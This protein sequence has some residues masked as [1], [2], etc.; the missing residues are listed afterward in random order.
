[1]AVATT[2]LLD[3]R[4]NGLGVSGVPLDTTGH[5]TL[6]QQQ[7]VAV[8]DQR[9]VPDTRRRGYSSSTEQ[10]LANT[11]RTDTDVAEGVRGPAA[12]INFPEFTPVRTL[13]HA[14]VVLAEWEGSVLTVEADK[15]TAQLTPISGVEKVAQDADVPCEEIS[16]DDRELVRVGALFRLAV[17][18]EIANGTRTRF[19]R[20][21]FR[22]LP[23]WTRR[24]IEDADALAER[25]FN[26]IRVE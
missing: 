15:I 9:L 4:S 22:R 24:D 23:A 11:V 21:V 17:G 20:I 25:Y 14:F 2:T 1:M 18:Y 8:A 10:S 3:Q 6:R 7:L 19:S 16:E 26:G 13:P 5:A 12:I